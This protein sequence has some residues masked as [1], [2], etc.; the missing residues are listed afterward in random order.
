MNSQRGRGLASSAKMLRR[1]ISR[2]DEA[3]ADEDGHQRAG[4]L[5]RRQ[6]EVLDDL[7]VLARREL[8]DQ[9]ATPATSSSANAPMP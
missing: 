1:S 5:D 7:D 4:E 8:A 3:D 6:A 2:D 9:R